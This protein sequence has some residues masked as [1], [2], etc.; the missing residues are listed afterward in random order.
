VSLLMLDLDHFKAINDLHG[1]L[2]GDQVLTAVADILRARAPGGAFIGRLGGEEFA[3]VLRDTGLQAAVGVAEFLRAAIG[4][5]PL[6]LR[7]KQLRVTISAGVAECSGRG[8]VSSD[9]L[10][11]AD[12][13]LYRAKQA[14][15]DRVSPEK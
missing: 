2:V 5:H 15:R 9:L 8:G 11:A 12:Q 14:G 3:V 13:Q 10:R 7:E 4:A 1:H 6:T